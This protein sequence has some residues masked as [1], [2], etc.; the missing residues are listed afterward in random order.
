MLELKNAEL[1]MLNIAWGKQKHG[2]AY[3]AS[4]GL[5]KKLA[6]LVIACYFHCEGFALAIAVC[7]VFM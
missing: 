3:F 4:T 7:A 2:L 5:G 1:M 6:P